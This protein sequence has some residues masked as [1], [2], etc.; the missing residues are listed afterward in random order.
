[1]ENGQD[2]RCPS[3]HSEKYTSLSFGNVLDSSGSA[4]T[5]R[6]LHCNVFFSTRAPVYR[7]STRAVKVG[8]GPQ[9]VA[10]SN[11]KGSGEHTPYGLLR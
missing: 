3:C 10:R 2:F 1:M 9:P 5:Y 8:V 11:L 6:C 7:P 4:S